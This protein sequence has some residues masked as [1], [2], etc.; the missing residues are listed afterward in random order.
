MLYFFLNIVFIHERHRERGRDIGRGRSRLPMGSLIRE[1][2]PGPRD[3]NLSQSRCSTLSHPGILS[4]LYLMEVSSI[5][6]KKGCYMRKER[7]ADKMFEKRQEVLESGAQVEALAFL[8][9]EGV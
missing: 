9:R 2:I 8:R 5:R 4:M 6:R 1:L 3:H 7:R